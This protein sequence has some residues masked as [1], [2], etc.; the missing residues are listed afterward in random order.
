MLSWLRSNLGSWISITARAERAPARLTIGITLGELPEGWFR[1]AH[2]ARTWSEIA[3]LILIAPF[4][5]LAAAGALKSLG[6]ADLYNWI[7]SEPAAIIAATLSL[8]V[9]IPVAVAM[10]FWRITRAGIK[11]EPG[12]LEGVVALEF[13]PLHLLVVGAA[14]IAGGAFLGHL[15]VD[16]YAC[17]RGVRAAC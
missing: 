12:S 1:R 11:T 13:A 10:N 6:L 5:A 15:L 8:F 7:A 3:G 9:G 4:I 17:W 14:L 2:H 16:G